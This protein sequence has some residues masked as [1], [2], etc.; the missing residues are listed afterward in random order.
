[1]AAD[2]PLATVGD[3]A[4][5]LQEQIPPD[6]PSALLYLR[7]ASGQVRDYLGQH[8]TKV[9]DDAVELDPYESR[10]VFLPELPIVSVSQVETL[11]DGVWT[12]RDPAEYTV[13]KRTG[14]IR[15]LTGGWPCSDGSWRVTY[16]HGLDVIPD[17]IVSVVLSVAGDG[18]ST[19]VGVDNERIGQRSIKYTARAREFSDVELAALDSHRLGR[20]G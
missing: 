15:V 18:Y 3:L 17:G 13:S 20:I 19:P 16:T 4:A 10:V 9:D 1:M 11:S 12:V 5:F 8:L 6:D 7:L 14:R 2:E